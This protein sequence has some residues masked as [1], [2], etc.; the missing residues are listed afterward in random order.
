M[1]YFSFVI[2]L[3]LLACAL[4]L[5]HAEVKWTVLF[6]PLPVMGL[7]VIGTLVGVFLVLVGM[8]YQDIQQALTIC[9]SALMFFT[10]VLYPERSGGIVGKIIEYNPITPFF[11]VC[12]E[13]LFSGQLA[14]IFEALVI[15]GVALILILAGWTLY[16]LA[17]PILIERM[18]A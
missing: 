11:T 9:T 2:K 5:F 7:L 14:S 8:L 15:F 4:L 13:M 6:L 3:V 12:R 16:K 17:M 10:P 18:E 1:P